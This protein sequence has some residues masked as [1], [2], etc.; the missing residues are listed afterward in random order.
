M[1]LTLR[2]LMVTRLTLL[3]QAH[4]FCPKP[5]AITFFFFFFLPCTELARYDGGD[6]VWKYN[7]APPYKQRA[8]YNT[9]ISHAPSTSRG[10]DR[11]PPVLGLGAGARV[12][13]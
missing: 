3:R 13:Y 4:P 12:S 9:I 2:M 7:T 10:W 5:C 6:T 8:I 1:N 11:G